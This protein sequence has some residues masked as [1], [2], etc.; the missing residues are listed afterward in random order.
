MNRALFRRGVDAWWMDATEPDLVQP[1]PPTLEATKRF[2]DRTAIGTAS[3]V[4][5]A[6]PLMNSKAVYDGQRS[7]APDQRVFILT[8]SGFAGIQRY[9]TVTW[10]G[11]I[12]S[13]FQTLRKQ[14]T[15][16]L[17]FSIAGDPY[18]TT[19]TGG[20]TMDRRLAQAKRRRRARR[21]AGVER[22]LVPVQHL[23]PHPPRAWHRPSA[24]NL[25]SRR[26]ELSRVPG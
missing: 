5:S 11:D 3:R 21:V 20:Y 12:T 22:T 8:R 15:A 4:M 2:I 23:L 1:S 6:Y 7:T 25:E 10:S 14:V 24:R 9:A 17:G 26:R 18:W 16:G 19:D 13:T